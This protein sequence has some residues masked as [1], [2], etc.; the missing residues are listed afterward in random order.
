MAMTMAENRMLNHA[1]RALQIICA[2]IVIGT[3]GYGTKYYCNLHFRH[4]FGSNFIV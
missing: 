1:V 2:L 3:D 4:A